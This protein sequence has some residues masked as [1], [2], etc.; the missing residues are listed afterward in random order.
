MHLPVVELLDRLAVV[1]LNEPA[2]LLLA[3]ERLDLLLVGRLGQLGAVHLNELAVPPLAAERLDPLA[4]AHLN[5]LAASL[6]AVAFHPLLPG[7]LDAVGGGW[8]NARLP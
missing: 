8:P 7:R 4:V 3:A 2:A 1:R 6:P 5:E